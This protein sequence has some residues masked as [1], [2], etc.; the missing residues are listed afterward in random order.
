MDR[1]CVTVH[2]ETVVT[3]RSLDSFNSSVVDIEGMMEVINLC[4]LANCY[5]I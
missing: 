5:N 3:L 2:N 4:E 1:T